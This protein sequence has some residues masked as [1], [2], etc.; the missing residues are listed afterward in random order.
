[1]ADHFALRFKVRAGDLGVTA[2]YDP[3]TDSL[4]SVE[5]N[6]QV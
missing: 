2:V 3:E 1:M 4:V 5:P 6:D